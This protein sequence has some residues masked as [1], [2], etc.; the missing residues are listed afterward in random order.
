MSVRQVRMTAARAVRGVLA[1]SA[2][3]ACFASTLP[4]RAADPSMSECLTANESAIKLR[5][6]HKLRQSRDQSL[7]CASSSCPGA[8]RDV[9]QARIRALSA[10]IPTVVFVAQDAGGHDVVAVRVSMDGE[11]VADRLDGTAVEVDP[12][13][14]TF[15]F[16]I[17]GQPAVERSLVV[18]EGQKNRRDVV[19]VGGGEAAPAGQPSPA[20]KETAPGI[21]TRRRG[22]DS[23]WQASWSASSAWPASRWAA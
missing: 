17:P 22:R 1:S 6:E 15:R 14:H 11:H 2:A 21:P 8:V 16:E 18:S 13:Q 5:G 12:G 7:V 20:P 9:C 23:A 4:A 19:P 10:A 3:L